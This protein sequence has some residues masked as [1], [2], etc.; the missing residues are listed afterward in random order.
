MAAM[1]MAGVASS[2]ASAQ[3]IEPPLEA[4]MT[5]A[6]TVTVTR[7]LLKDTGELLRELPTSRYKLAQFRDGRLRMTMLAS[8][9][10]PRIGPMADPYAGMV[11]EGNLAQG[12][13]ELRDASGKRVGLPASAGMPPAAEPGESFLAD[14]GETPRRRQALERDYGRPTGRLRGLMRYV[15]R[16]GTTTEEVLV[17]SDTML[18][19]EL[20][21][22]KN[23]VLTEHHAFSYRR[24]P[25]NRWVRQQSVAHTLVAGSQPQRMLS[26]TTLDDIR[27]DGGAR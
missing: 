5:M 19:A 14:T 15:A 18:P 3:T 11:V 1:V 16:R 17:A 7:A 4:G 12:T 26:I 25:G 6:A 21:V 8:R 2:G 23:G 27:T 20:N 24:L 10:G 13:L 22:V 9:P